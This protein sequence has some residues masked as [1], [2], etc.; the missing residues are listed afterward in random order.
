MRRRTIELQ[1]CPQALR[2]LADALEDYIRIAFPGGDQCTQVSRQALSDALERLRAPSVE[3]DMAHVEL[4]RR[5]RA[6]LKAAIKEHL[7]DPPRPSQRD[8]L[9]GLLGERPLDCLR[10]RAA[11]DA[12]DVPGGPRR[13]EVDG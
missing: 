2:T 7:D 10:W 4:S 11:C 9:M 3:A 1:G 8:A 12:D 5:L 6:Q 13:D